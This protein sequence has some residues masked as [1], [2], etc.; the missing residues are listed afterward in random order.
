[1][2]QKR[3]RTCWQL[4]SGSKTRVIMN[5]SFCPHSVS[6]LRQCPSNGCKI[7]NKSWISFNFHLA[8][9]VGSPDTLVKTDV[10]TVLVKDTI[11]RRDQGFRLARRFFKLAG[12][13]FVNQA[14]LPL[15]ETKQLMNI[16]SS[17]VKHFTRYVRIVKLADIFQKRTTNTRPGS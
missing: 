3:Y 1:M 9:S 8:C 2:D 5:Q 16:R 4:L 12:I 7:Q 15:T 6:E 13:H 10:A 17:H 14:T 11:S